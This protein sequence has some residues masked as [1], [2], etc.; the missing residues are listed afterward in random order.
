MVDR[1]TAAQPVPDGMHKRRALVAGAGV[2]FA[3]TLAKL[4]TPER[5][6]AHDPQDVGLDINNASAGQTTITGSGTGAY[7]F[8]V[9]SANQ[10]AI[11]GDS[12]GNPA[13]FAVT[14]GSFAMW[15]LAQTN[16]QGVH[17]NSATGIAIEANSGGA[18]NA[19]I[20]SVNTAGGI[21]VRALSTSGGTGGPGV[22]AQTNAFAA[23]QGSASTSGQGVYGISNT[24]FG[25]WG[26]TN[27]A[28]GMGGRF[29]NSTNGDGVYGSS[30]GGVAVHG[31]SFGTGGFA[32]R[33]DG[34]VFITGNFQALGT[35]SAIVPG[36]GGQMVAVYCTESPESWFEDFGQATLTNGRAEV[37]IAPDFLPTI[38]TGKPYH[39]FLTSHSAD[40]ESLAVTSRGPDR[41]V[42]EANGKGRVDGTF[43]YRIVALRKNQPGERLATV[44]NADVGRPNSDARPPTPPVFPPYVPTQVPPMPE[45]KH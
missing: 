42:V 43:S 14:N 45:P 27:G 11:R 37:P 2:A 21:A 30:V 10:S 25:V 16:G 23:I 31:Q 20:Q 29:E 13:I 12:P 44:K 34:D 19:T 17:A 26:Q 15:G 9:N 18:G 40:I 6:L 8:Y 41:F 1:N 5:A 38:D 4:A 32:G 7:T 3:A 39:V 22:V 24:G 28:S 33:F 35:K 36:L